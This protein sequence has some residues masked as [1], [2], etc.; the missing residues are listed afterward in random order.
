LI[1]KNNIIVYKTN[2][3]Y[4][5]IYCNHN[6]IDIYSSMHKTRHPFQWQCFAPSTKP[7]SYSPKYSNRVIYWNI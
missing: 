1:N 4:N 5:I 2:V 3:L 6:A 7:S